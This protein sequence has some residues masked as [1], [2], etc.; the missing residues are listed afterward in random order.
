MGLRSEMLELRIE[1]RLSYDEDSNT[2]FMD[3]SGTHGRTPED[4][5]RIVEVVDGLLA[6]LGRRVNS[7]VN[8][9]RFQLD[10]A[11]VDEYADAIR[12]VQERYYL[13]GGVTRHSTNAFMRL[14][15]GRELEKRHLKPSI[16]SSP[17]EADESI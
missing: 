4:V 5:D 11:A 1:D 3:Y 7:V 12:Y 14:K 13:K 17:E 16:Y 2:G 6:P 15:L 10:E 8:Y 9:D